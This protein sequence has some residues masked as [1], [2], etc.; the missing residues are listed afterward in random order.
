[1]IMDLFNDELAFDK[2][3]K[4][5]QKDQPLAYRMRPVA[6]DD[7]I[8]QD[9]IVGPG[10]LL[11]RLIETDQM[12]S[13]ILCGPPGSG[14]T[15][16][17]LL[18]ARL[19]KRRFVQISAVTS[20]VAELRQIIEQAHYHYTHERKTIV[21][22]DEIHRFNKAQQDVLLPFIEKG[23][24]GLIG[25]TTENPFYAL[26]APLISR[27]QVFRLNKLQN[28]DLVQIMKRS[29]ADK[30]RGFGAHSVEMSEQAFDVLATLS[31]GDARKALSALEVAVKS[32]KKD[33]KNTLVIS[34]EIAEESIQKKLVLY[35]KKGDQHY[36]TISA[37]IKSM[38]GTDPD[39]ALYWLAK[40][41]EAGEDI[42]FIARRIVICASEDVGNADPMALVVATSALEAVRTIGLPEAR[43]PLAQ[44]TVY[45]ACAPK[46]NA[47]YRGISLASK[48]IQKQQTQEVPGHI[49]NKKFFEDKDKEYLYPH[50]YDGHVIEQKYMQR[51][52][53]FYI[54]SNEGYEKKIGDRLKNWQKKVTTQSAGVQSDNGKL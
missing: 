31:D 37:F 28:E 12:N 23:D 13:I 3:I 53:K 11:R 44:A 48:E 18:I 49:K 20:N 29:L 1:M 50:D 33:K 45:I 35:D 15:S 51:K 2:N 5:A 40:M 7:L 8:G 38:R 34:K 9:H 43:I 54:P 47:S 46:S 6:L 32:S 19:T 26:N 52:K 22:I 17:A 10:K 41:L 25:A 42:L 24:I 4:I 27:S 39:A 21:F 36:D 14:K 16:L 30:V